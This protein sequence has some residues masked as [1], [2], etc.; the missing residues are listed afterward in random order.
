M[1]PLTVYIE[2]IIS[3]TAAAATAITTTYILAPDRAAL[4]LAVGSESDVV[5][6]HKRIAGVIPVRNRQAAVYAS[7]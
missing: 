2:Y 4:G 3:I 1:S 7:K 6:G 5:I